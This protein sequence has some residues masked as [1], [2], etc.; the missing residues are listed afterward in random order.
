[1]KKFIIIA[2]II[3]CI[4]SFSSAAKTKNK[5]LYFYG[6]FGISGVSTDDTIEPFDALDFSFNPGFSLRI[7]DALGKG[8]F[9]RVDFGYLEVNWVTKVIAAPYLVWRGRSYLNINGVIASKKGNFWIGGGIYFAIGIEGWWISENAGPESTSGSTD[10][11]LLV[12]VGYEL[13]DRFFLGFQARYGLLSQYSYASIHNY[14]LYGTL[15][16]KLTSF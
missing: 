13:S 5:H 6:G 9:F 12:D 15:G 11:G 3:L 2:L 16:F 4:S 10:F 1:M 14:V 8:S 7:D